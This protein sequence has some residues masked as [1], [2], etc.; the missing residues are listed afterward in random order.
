MAEIS[1]LA[2]D[3]TNRRIT[4]SD[5]TTNNRILIGYTSSNN[6]IIAFLS[7]GGS[8]QF[9]SISSIPKST[10]FN[11]ISIKYKVNDFALWVNGFKLATD[12]SGNAPIGLNTL[13][14]KDGNSTLDFYGK[15]RELQYFDSVLTDAQLETLTSWTSLQEMIT[16]QLYTN[17]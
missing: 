4:L 2:N 11:K 12:T 7:S 3:G 13:Q 5:G 16:S 1:A 6:E 9:V 14:F 17:Y 15:T 10:D 8:S